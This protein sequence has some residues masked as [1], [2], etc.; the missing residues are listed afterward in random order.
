MVAYS[1]NWAKKMFA[2]DLSTA[3]KLGTE[4]GFLT[5]FI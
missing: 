5:K 2:P 4:C 3:V 1:M